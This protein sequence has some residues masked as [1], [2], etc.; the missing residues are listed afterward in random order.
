MKYHKRGGVGGYDSAF[1]FEIISRR[2]LNQVFVYNVSYRY[3]EVQNKITIW[4][5]SI[6]FNVELN[7]SNNLCGGFPNMFTLEVCNLKMLSYISVCEF[8]MCIIPQAGQIYTLGFYTKSQVFSVNE[9]RIK[10]IFD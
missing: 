10:D 4:L 9:N 2:P 3:R 5:C 6:Y 8:Q 7:V 1:H